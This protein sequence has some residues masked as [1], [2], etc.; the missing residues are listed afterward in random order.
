MQNG[1]D[2]SGDVHTRARTLI[3]DLELS[4]CSI[5]TQAKHPELFHYTKPAAFENIVKSNAFWASHYRDMADQRE[6]L[7]MRNRLPLA[8]ASGGTRRSIGQ[9]L[10]HLGLGHL[11]QAVVTSEDVTRQKPAPDIFLEAARRLG[12][13]PGRCRAYEDTELGMQ[14]IRAAG[15]E[16]VDVRNLIQK[17]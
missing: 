17:A 7:L 6:V 5:E 14:A 13:P 8:V 3:A 16:A 4:V 15:M 11:F 9:V 10:D 12:M 2:C 1:V